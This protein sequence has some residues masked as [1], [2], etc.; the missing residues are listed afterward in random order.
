LGICKEVITFCV[1]SKKGEDSV[2][3]ATAIK[4]KKAEIK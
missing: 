2:A 1:K 4:I 3:K